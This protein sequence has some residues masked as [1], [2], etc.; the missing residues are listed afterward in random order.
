MGQK[1]GAL[2]QEHPHLIG[3]LTFAGFLPLFLHL[4]LFHANAATFVG[5]HHFELLFGFHIPFFFADHTITIAIH[6]FKI[7]AMIFLATATLLRHMTVTRSSQE[8]E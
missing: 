2:L 5:V 3:L 4:P 6:F 7:G 8:T 1:K